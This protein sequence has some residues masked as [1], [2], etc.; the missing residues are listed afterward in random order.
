MIRKPMGLVSNS[1][2]LVAYQYTLVVALAVAIL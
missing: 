1:R 2:A